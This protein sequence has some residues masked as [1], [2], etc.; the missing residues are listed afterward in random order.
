MVI[1]EN[2]SRWDHGDGFEVEVADSQR[3]EILR[4]DRWLVVGRDAAF[5]FVKEVKEHDH[6]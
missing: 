3:E 5:E 6:F 4:V 1:S 2:D